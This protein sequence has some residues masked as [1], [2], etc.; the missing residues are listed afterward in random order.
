[1]VRTKLQRIKETLETKFHNVLHTIRYILK[2]TAR[3]SWLMMQI[4]YVIVWRIQQQN[5]RTRKLPYRQS[6][7]LV[8][9]QFFTFSIALEV[10]NCKFHAAFHQIGKCSNRTHML[11][12]SSRHNCENFIAPDIIVWIDVRNLGKAVKDTWPHLPTGRT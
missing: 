12:I 4:N 9:Y 11:Y 3:K 8:D 7:M 5:I 2:L 10:V 6:Y 1:M